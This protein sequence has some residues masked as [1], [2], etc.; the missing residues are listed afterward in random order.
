AE[1]RRM[2]IR[3]CALSAS[4]G[5]A[6]RF[7][8]IG[9]GHARLLPGAP[10]CA[11]LNRRP[12]DGLPALS[13]G[14]QIYAHAAPGPRPISFALVTMTA[15]DAPGEPQWRLASCVGEARVSSGAATR[16]ID[17]APRPDRDGSVA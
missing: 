6:N 7:H 8:D 1:V 3:Q 9:F 12:P 17:L 14:P 16:T 10:K 5:R 4:P 11:S 2:D 13:V 15:S